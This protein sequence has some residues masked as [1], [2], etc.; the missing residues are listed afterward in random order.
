MPNWT[1]AKTT[2]SS[3]KPK[4]IKKILLNIKKYGMNWKNTKLYIS[5]EDKDWYNKRLFEWSTKWDMWKESENEKRD[6]LS[7][8]FN[9][10]ES[11]YKS[12]ITIEQSYPNRGP[13]EFLKTLATLFTSTTIEHTEAEAG[14]SYAYCLEIN[15]GGIQFENTVELLSQEAIDILG[16]E[17]WLWQLGDELTYTK[18]LE[19]LLKKYNIAFTTEEDTIY[20]KNLIVKSIDEDDSIKEELCFMCKD[21]GLDPYRNSILHFK[22]KKLTY[23]QVENHIRCKYCDTKPD[24]DTVL[25]ILNNINKETD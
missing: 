17:E 16:I 15:D 24:K 14:D 6:R 3:D 20:I 1:N 9:Y 10:F 5:E 8:R 12:Y 19:N 11:D 18:E 23:K 2:I 22:G 13:R 4:D 21:T 25:E 7:L